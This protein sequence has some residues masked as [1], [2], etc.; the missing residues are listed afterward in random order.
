MKKILVTGGHGFIAGYVIEELK[1]QGY[2]PVTTVRH[3]EPNPILDDV[4]VYHAEMT[5]EAEI[6]SVVQKCDAV[7]HLACISNDPSFE[8]QPELAKSINFDCFEPMV[9]A[10]R[11][12]GSWR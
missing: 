4:I 8:L 9:A 10:I 6:Y 2:Q 7:I 12:A 11:E 3:S 5:N 1:R